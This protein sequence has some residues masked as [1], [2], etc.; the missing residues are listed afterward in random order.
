MGDSDK[1]KGGTITCIRMRTTGS[2]SQRISGVQ[3]GDT[4]ELCLKF[5]QT[6]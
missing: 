5:R 6:G 3:G 2:R 4:S 1:E